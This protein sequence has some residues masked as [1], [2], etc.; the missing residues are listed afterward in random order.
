MIPMRREF[1]ADEDLAGAMLYS[2]EVFV[3]KV[4]GF[5]PER[6]NAKFIKGKHISAQQQD[7]LLAVEK[8]MIG[9]APRKISVKSGNGIG[10]SSVASWIIL[11][12]LFAFKN[13]QVAVT[14][15]SSSQIFDVLWKECMKWISMM[16]EPVKMKYDWNT[17]HIRMAENPFVWFARAATGKKESPEALA[18]LHSEHVLLVGDEAS[19]IPNEIFEIAE[20]SLTEKNTLVILP[21]NPTR[22]TGYF[23]ETFN[24]DKA[25][26]Q[27]LSF[28]SLESP[29]VNAKEFAEGFEA[30]YGL[31]SDEYRIHVLGEFPQADAVDDAGYISLFDTEDLS[32]CADT[33]RFID[34]KLG[35]DPAGEGENNA[36]WVIRDKF[37]AK[38]VAK[39][40][41]STPRS[42]ALKTSTLMGHYNIKPG[43][44]SVDDFGPGAKMIQELSES[45][46]GRVRAVNVGMPPDDRTRYINRRAENYMRAKTWLK[47]G[48]ELVKGEGWDQLLDIKYRRA[49]SGKVQI[50]GKREMRKDGVDDLGVADAFMLT[51]DTEDRFAGTP[52]SAGVVDNLSDEE[53]AAITSVYK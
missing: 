11:W 3:R 44:T 29:L 51:F 47:Q 9:E 37:R 39:E 23:Y 5:V 6:D 20:G 24:K 45:G 8:A 32:F 25:R 22:L 30:K 1:K 10:K 2:P 48:G 27:N 26:W 52:S 21:S 19:G 31:D 42:G 15:P 12:F 4:F 38:I 7:I 43:R 33:G 28:S 36:V 18:G 41:V 49:L 34:P 40:M 46:V 50:K 17:T 53:I 16:P 14:A 35:I 13:S